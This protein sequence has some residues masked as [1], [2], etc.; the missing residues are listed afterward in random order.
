ME[1]GWGR[2]EPAM[3]WELRLAVDG[4]AVAAVETCFRGEPVLRHDQVEGVEE[5]IPH[6]L[7]EQ[8]A[9]RVA[10]RS[11]TR[12]NH[13]TRHPTTQ[14]LILTLDAP[15]S[16]RIHLTGNGLRVCYT[17]A[18]LLEGSRAHM[19]AGFASP[20]VRLHRAVAERD[21]RLRC[22]AVDT[23][24][25]REVDYYYLRLAQRNAQCAW[26]SPVWVTA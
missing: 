5:T 14:A 17:L 7:L 25:E 9:T 12:G 22:T 13:S 15:P 16:A 23:V 11:L 6:A 2:A 20:A 18:Q 1:W 3:P 10:W 26:L 24:P 8:T 4:G 19:T 21:Y